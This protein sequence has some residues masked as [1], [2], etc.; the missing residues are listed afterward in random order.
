M[1]KASVQNGNVD[2]KVQG[3]LGVAAWWMVQRG[4]YEWETIRQCITDAGFDADKLCPLPE[5]SALAS[6]AFKDA[7]KIVLGGRDEDEDG[8]AIATR[9]KDDEKVPEW[10]VKRTA[11]TEKY[12]KYSLLK[13]AA[14]GEDKAT[15]EQEMLFRVDRDPTSPNVVSDHT[16]PIAKAIVDKFHE[17]YGKANRGAIV[18]A[19]KRLVQQS[20]G[21][22]L[23]PTGGIY[24]V[25]EKNAADLEKFATAFNA[26]GMGILFRMT[27]PGD[28]SSLEAVRAA[29][30]EAAKDAFKGFQDEIAKFDGD[31]RSSTLADRLEQY[32]ALADQGEFFK[33][34]YGARL[35]WLDDNLK[36][37]REK[38]EALLVAAPKAV[39]KETKAAA[40]AERKAKR[41]EKKAVRA[42]KKAQRAEKKAAKEKAEAEK[43]AKPVEKPAKKT[44]K[45]PKAVVKAE[46]TPVEAPKV[47]DGKKAKP[48]PKAV[49]FEETPVDVQAIRDKVLRGKKTAK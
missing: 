48:A 35:E 18:R 29:A 13:I 11:T 25:P 5:N 1:A 46:P 37:L 23:R 22:L 3:N 8:E 49:K 32:K 40:K 4:I 21:F 39:D 9:S 38:V 7:H 27:A 33:M 28:A 45:A 17:C 47:K 15:G 12:L 43:A 14:Q 19:I 16:G 44:K 10:R 34:A 36:D 24:F 26:S 30:E 41:E 42:A 6:R 20:Q 31:T 2:Q